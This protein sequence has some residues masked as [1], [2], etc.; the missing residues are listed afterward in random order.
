[1]RVMRHT[2][3]MACWNS[4]KFMTAHSGRGRG[5]AWQ[6]EQSAK[7]ARRG[8]D[9]KASILTLSPPGLFSLYSASLSSSARLSASTDGAQ[10]YTGSSFASR[11]MN[12]LNSSGEAS[13]A[14]C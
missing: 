11:A 3:S 12:E 9:E 5:Q 2:C 4:T 8:R 10:V 13:M 1:M 6:G 14:S 7:P